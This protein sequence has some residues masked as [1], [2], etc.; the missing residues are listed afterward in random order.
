[1]DAGSN[2]LHC[3][4]TPSANRCAQSRLRISAH[5]AVDTNIPVYADPVAAVKLSH[6]VA[7]SH[8]QEARSFFYVGVGTELLTFDT[9]SGALLRAYAVFEPPI[10]PKNVWYGWPRPANTNRTIYFSAAY[11]SI[12]CCPLGTAANCMRSICSRGVCSG[13]A[14]SGR[15]LLRARPSST[16]DLPP[17]ARCV[18]SSKVRLQGY[19]AK[20]AASQVSTTGY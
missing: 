1:M 3:G 17:R 20:I 19:G 9:R 7:S 4:G 11:G 14:W 2:P 8:P 18:C 16:N 13:V 6:S 15:V 10:D 12:G 5:R